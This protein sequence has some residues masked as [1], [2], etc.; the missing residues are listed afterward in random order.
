[1]EKTY[2]VTLVRLPN[3]TLGSILERRPGDRT[4]TPTNN[5]IGNKSCCT[6]PWPEI[7]FEGRSSSVTEL[8]G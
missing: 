1:M 7:R 5:C 4:R 8:P 3:Q 6:S 2:L